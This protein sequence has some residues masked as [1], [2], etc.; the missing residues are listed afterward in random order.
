[1]INSLSLVIPVYNEE[2]NIKKYLQYYL[3]KLKVSNIQFE[4]I[5]VESNSQDQSRQIL[6][7]FLKKKN[8]KIVIENSKNGYGSAIKLGLRHV[9]KKFV[10]FFPI[11]NQYSINELIRIC[12][13]N[14]G[15][16]VTYRKLNE[17]SIIK[18]IRSYLYKQIC[19]LFFQLK[20]NDINSIKIISSS[21]LKKKKIYNNLSNIWIIDLEILLFLKKYKIYAKQAGISLRSRKNDKSKVSILDNVL[22]FFIII[23]TRLKFFLY[24]FII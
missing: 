1:M 11:D 6:N 5:I 19:S 4:I 18:K 10:T 21:F 14:S 22:L 7:N 12:Q 9:K 13:N 24:F 8:F 20:F 17:N 15:N 23:R 3:D 16:I 2:K